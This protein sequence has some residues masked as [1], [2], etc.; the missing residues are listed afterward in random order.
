MAHNNDALYDAVVAGAGG[1]AQHG[2]LILSTPASYTP[3]ANNIDI[4]ATAVDLQIPVIAGGASISQI[5]LLQSI[6]HS[7]LTARYPVP[8]APATYIDIAKAIAA[9]YT[10]LEKLLT[11]QPTVAS[12]G[13][14]WLVTDWYID[15]TVG[16]DA[17]SGVVIGAPI[18]TGAELLRRLGPYAIWPQSV[19]VHV[20][21]NGMIDALVLRGLMMVAGTHLDVV[22]TPTVLISGIVSAFQ[23][24]DHTVPRAT[25]LTTVSFGDW[26]PYLGKRVTFTSGT[27]IGG[28]S[29]VGLASPGG[30]G[31]NIAQIS[32]PA[33]IETA[34]VNGL[35]NITTIVVAVGNTFDV[36]NVPYVPELS[37]LIDGPMNITNGNK[38]PNRQWTIQ[39][40]SCP[41]IS[42]AGPGQQVYHKSLIFGC[43][44]GAIIDSAPKAAYGLFAKIA[45]CV[46]HQDWI[47]TFL[48]V[49]LAGYYGNSMLYNVAAQSLPQSFLSFSYTLLQGSNL[50][51]SN[52]T[53][54][55]WSNSQIFDYTG[56]SFALSMS[57]ADMLFC[58]GISG[59]RNIGYGYGVRDNTRHRISGTPNLQGSVSNVRFIATT[60]MNLTWPAFLQRSDYAQKGITPAMVAG[61]T[62]VTVPWYDNAV[63][64]VT[65]SHAV[66]GGTPG[67]LSV[68]QISTTQFTI[69]SSSALDTSTVRWHIS[70]LGRNIFVTTV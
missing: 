20:L 41:V 26:T 57:G 61:T 22:G 29:W 21:A 65:V 1:G 37:L 34:N 9:V 12:Y 3:F 63:Q 17:N 35:T 2:W 31:V 36:E 48:T 33:K 62:T 67:I 13:V 18:K 70:P 44:T 58:N 5:N 25:L 10:E 64:Q 54:L 43:V 49:T 4:L 69:T 52:G 40:I 19:T 50:G 14:N 53:Q 8:V 7:V 47:D 68:Q 66:F 59:A 30:V 16:D 23:D 56:G 15:G 55:S 32:R 45:C 60:A 11:N 6:T 38:W 46:A 27:G 51:C 39:S 24:F 28:T 42:V